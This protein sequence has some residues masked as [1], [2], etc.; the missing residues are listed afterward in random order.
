ME[1]LKKEDSAKKMRQ[2]WDDLPRIKHCYDI[3][4]DPNGMRQYQVCGKSFQESATIGY[5]IPI[6]EKFYNDYGRRA[7]LAAENKN[8]D[9]KAVSHALRAAYQTKEILT[10][11]N[12]I[13]P[14]KMAPF[15]MKV[16][17]GKLDYLTEV[18]PVLESLMEEVEELS[19]S[20]TLPE[21]VDRKFWDQFICD[22]IES[23]LFS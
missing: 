4:P 16:K 13:F 12:L 8:I 1:L 6:L 19:L 23:E 5:V 21:T 9:W 11:N 15:L 14:L 10:E 20:S 2:I 17:Q 22:A 18:A 3:A 7:R